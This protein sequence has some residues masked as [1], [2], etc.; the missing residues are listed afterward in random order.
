MALN[1]G[2][3]KQ[4]AGCHGT[5][6]MQSSVKLSHAES[7]KKACNSLNNSKRVSYYLRTA[8]TLG[9]ILQNY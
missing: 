4:N 6:L 7:Q 8:D 5:P 2:A 9:D 1:G 3:E